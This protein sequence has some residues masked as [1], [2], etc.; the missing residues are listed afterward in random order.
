MSG[1]VVIEDEDE[2]VV[3]DICGERT[4]EGVQQFLVKWRGYIDS[5]TWEPEENLANCA[6]MLQAFKSA[7][8]KQ[9]EPVVP[10]KRTAKTPAAPRM[11][12]SRQCSECSVHVQLSQASRADASGTRTY[13]FRCADCRAKARTVHCSVCKKSIQL[14]RLSGATTGTRKFTC[15]DC[16]AKVRTTLCGDCSRSAAV[17]HCPAGSYCSVCWD[18]ARTV[19]CAGCRKDVLM[20]KP[21]QASYERNYRCKDCCGFVCPVCGDRVV[22]AHLKYQARYSRYEACAACKQASGAG[23]VGGDLLKLAQASPATI[24]GAAQLARYAQMTPT[25]LPSGTVKLA[26]LNTGNGNFT[27]TFNLQG[28]SASGIDWRVYGLTASWSI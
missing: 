22:G 18:K 28:K 17:H 19:R 10:K 20:A 16:R 27:T 13:R 25:N 24:M 14:Q 15:V 1:T 2:F 23:I 6:D 21:S 12:C 4:H 9:L 7:A 3:E 5:D 8:E 26:Q 11:L